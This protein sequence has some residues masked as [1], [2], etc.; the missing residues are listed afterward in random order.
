MV[1]ICVSLMTND[2]E[3]IL[4]CINHL[5]IFIIEVAIHIFCPLLNWVICLLR[6][7]FFLY[8][9]YKPFIR[10]IRAV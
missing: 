7:E 5:L 1:L 2:V 9:R 4:M 8:T 6:I 3:H 10:Y